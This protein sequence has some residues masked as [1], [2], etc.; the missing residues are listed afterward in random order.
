MESVNARIVRICSLTGFLVLQKE[1]D[2]TTGQ[3]FSG[4]GTDLIITLGG[5]DE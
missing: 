5:Q 2:R 1:K 3:S 4:N